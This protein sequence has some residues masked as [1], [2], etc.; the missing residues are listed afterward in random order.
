MRVILYG[1]YK[2]RDVFGHVQPLDFQLVVSQRGALSKGQDSENEWL[3]FFDDWE[4]IP[5]EYGQKG[6]SDPN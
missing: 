5:E 6:P 3:V 1:W 2:Y 4:A